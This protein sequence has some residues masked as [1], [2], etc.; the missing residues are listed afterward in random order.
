[1]MEKLKDFLFGLSNLQVIRVINRALIYT[2]PVILIGTVT[3]A[4]LNLPIPAFQNFMF[5]LF[6]PVWRDAALAVYHGS[7]QIVGLMLVI[8]VS[9]VLS[10]EKPEVKQGRIESV[11][12]VLTALGSYVAYSGEAGQGLSLK[13]LSALGI[14][15]VLAVSVLATHLFFR[16]YALYVSLQHRVK[17]LRISSNAFLRTF[18]RIVVPT[19]ATIAFFALA[20]L[21][22]IRVGWN[23]LSDILLSDFTRTLLSGDG[24]LSAMLVALLIHFF[25]FFG[26]HGGM[27]IMDTISSANL[28]VALSVADT[29]M[30]SIL[31]KEFFD[32]FIH[33]GGSGAT[34]G[35][36]LALLFTETR[37]DATQ[38]T[39]VSFFLGVFNINDL[40]VYRLPIMFNPYYFIP[41]VCTPVIL[42]LVSLASMKL[43][44]VPPISQEVEW[45]TPIFLSGYLVTGSAAG[46]FLQA[47]NLILSALIYLPFVNMHRAYLGRSRR[48][49]F[50]K[51]C[52][53]IC[54][55]PLADRK[56]LLSRSDEVGELAASLLSEIRE[57]FSSGSP[58]FHLEYQPKVDGAGRAVGAE[59]L[60]RWR[61]SFYG[62]VPP[63][64]T[65]ALCDEGGLT[66]ALGVWVLRQGTADL[67]R[68]AD[69]GYENIVVS[70]NINPLQIR[71]DADFAELVE[72]CIRTAGIRPQSLELE[73]T[74]NAAL[75]PGGATFER[76]QRI[77][78]LGCAI[79]I[80]DFGMGHSS[81]L[82]ISDFCAGVVK[83]DI[84]L[85]RTIA[86]DKNR[87][88]IVKSILN[89]CREID[90]EV[91]A[92][93][94]E[95]EAQLAILK[96]YGCKYYQGYYFSKP[97]GFDDF[98]A[99]LK[100][101]G[102]AEKASDVPAK[103]C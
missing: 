70:V 6:G 15:D 98:I 68:I 4:F 102:T 64:V 25:W 28:A 65:V 3:F 63:P 82:Y 8:T 89:L 97:C 80:D 34:F 27:L 86:T 37:R 51:L 14:F 24:Y 60:L 43:G 100:E 94:V 71:D 91:I 79:S 33:M 90:V 26:A 55:A 29:G 49:L 36:L 47:F 88:Q 59:A 23:G 77:R 16:I 12:V 56:P 85:I 10:Q 57:G 48:M 20:K 13:S 101:R 75:D 96:E 73:I 81:L 72:D 17:A 67:R 74:E 18:F 32:V 9:Y 38:L 42:S 22:F 103:S 5:G 7:M 76:L 19:W 21:F 92:E 30:L 2:T 53:E 11:F 78:T 41:F 95:T 50:G 31:S 45:T 87:Q 39:R 54:A 44:L 61:H 52:D 69:R 58:L 99:Y 66:A 1:M 35:L 46:S 62:A 84:A 40:M 93:G 83:L